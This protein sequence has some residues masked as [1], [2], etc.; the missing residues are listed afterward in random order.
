MPNP[1]YLPDAQNFIK[2]GF[3]VYHLR[4]TTNS[5]SLFG[6]GGAWNPGL[7]RGGTKTRGSRPSCWIDMII[8]LVL[9]WTNMWSFLQL[10]SSAESF[11]TLKNRESIHFGICCQRLC[12]KESIHDT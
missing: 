3:Y 2:L 6:R 10:P 5:Q 11:L 7:T 9:I 8:M 1:E 12:E 4:V